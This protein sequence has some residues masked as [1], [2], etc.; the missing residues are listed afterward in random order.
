LPFCA[1]GVDGSG[2]AGG[3]A[4]PVEPVTRKGKKKCQQPPFN[5]F[6]SLGNSLVEPRPNFKDACTATIRQGA[7]ENV[8]E[9]L[10]IHASLYVLA[11]KWG[12][13]SLKKLS[14]FK[15]HTTLGIL[16]LD[17]PRARAIVDL[18]RYAY[19]DENI[20][21]LDNGLDGLRELICEYILSRVEVVS[22]QA[23]FLDLMEEGGPFVRDLWRATVPRVSFASY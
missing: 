12:G 6:E 7:D 11:E 21:D 14:L 10:L 19:S 13:D 16:Q 22:K 15:L 5:T 1:A 8:G 4:E 23:T 9:V 2:L 20:P 18:A 3:V 17:P